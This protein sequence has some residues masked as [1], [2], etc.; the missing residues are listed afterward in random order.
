MVK[1]L[2][3]YMEG[4]EDADIEVYTAVEEVV[5]DIAHKAERCTECSLR[6][7]EV[8]PCTKAKT[9]SPTL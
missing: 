6:H 1:H 8:G 7:Q 4:Q 9:S 2:H 3:Q 5:K